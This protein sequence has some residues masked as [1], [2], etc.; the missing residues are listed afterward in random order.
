MTNFCPDAQNLPVVTILKISLAKKINK[1]FVGTSK[2]LQSGGKNCFQDFKKSKSTLG[3]YNLKF[4]FKAEK[5]LNVVL[6][7]GEIKCFKRKQGTVFT[8]KYHL[9]FIL[10]CRNSCIFSSEETNI[11]K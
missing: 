4:L 6:C 5:N 9:F 8:G 3:I 7:Q 1:I 10:W 11:F 2:F